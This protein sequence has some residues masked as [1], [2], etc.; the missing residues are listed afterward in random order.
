MESSPHSLSDGESL[1]E[2]LTETPEMSPLPCPLP[3]PLLYPFEAS[4]AGFLF[5]LAAG[6][7]VLKLQ[8][9]LRGSPEE[10]IDVCLRHLPDPSHPNSVH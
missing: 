4:G 5:L 3:L 1:P 2:T 7:Q 9:W 10:G 6:P 8:P